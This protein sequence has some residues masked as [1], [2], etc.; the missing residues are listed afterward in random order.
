MKS[1]IEHNFAVDNSLMDPGKERNIDIIKN[2]FVRIGFDETQKGLGSKEDLIDYLD[3]KQLAWEKRN[4]GFQATQIRDE[5]IPFTHIGIGAHYFC[6]YRY[7]KKTPIA[8]K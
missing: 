6:G 1:P 5:I 7:F 2:G 3:Q 4:P 8:Q